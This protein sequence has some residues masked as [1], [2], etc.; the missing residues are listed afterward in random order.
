M[1]SKLVLPS[2]ITLHE[3]TVR[4]LVALPPAE[5]DAALRDMEEGRENGTHLA[6][7]R[8]RR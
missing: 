2:T 6:L 7:S 4:L 1:E 8:V 5:R 3:A